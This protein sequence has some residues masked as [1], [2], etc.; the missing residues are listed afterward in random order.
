MLNACWRFQFLHIII[1]YGRYC[2][3]CIVDW[4]ESLV[5]AGGHR[6][7]YTSPDVPFSLLLIKNG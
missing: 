3:D 6:L 5:A 4:I 1:C 7:E 2:K